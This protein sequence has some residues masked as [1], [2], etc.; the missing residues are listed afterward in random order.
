[1]INPYAA[2]YDAVM[3]VRRWRDVQR[4]GYD[5]QELYAV[6]E[7]GTLPLQLLQPGINRDPKSVHCK[8]SHTLLRSGC[9][10]PGG[11]PGHSAAS[12]WKDPGALCGGVSPI[13]LSVAV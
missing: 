3:T 12:D 7:G 2:M 9:G 8:Q 4:G 10:Y 11:G 1:M 13:H 6:E 5:K